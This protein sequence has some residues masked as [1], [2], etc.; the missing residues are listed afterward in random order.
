MLQSFPVLFVLLVFGA[1][2][3]FDCS[4]SCARGSFCHQPYCQP[5]GDGTGIWICETGGPVRG[6][7]NEC[8]TSGCN[9]PWGCNLVSFDSHK[10]SCQTVDTFC[11]TKPSACCKD[12]IQCN[13]IGSPCT[14][15]ITNSTQTSPP[16]KSKPSLELIIVVTVSS[17]FLV[18]GLMIAILM[19]WRKRNRY[20]QLN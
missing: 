2:A 7:I 16:P 5:N 10:D 19:Y 15:E 6:H 8:N 17:L 14:P 12:D 4:Y 1:N 18:S 9:P 20:S 13:F 11:Q 3:R